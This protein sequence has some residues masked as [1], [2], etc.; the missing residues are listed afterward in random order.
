[1]HPLVRNNALDRYNSFM[2]EKTIMDRSLVVVDSLKE[3]K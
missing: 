2:R 1:M 3:N